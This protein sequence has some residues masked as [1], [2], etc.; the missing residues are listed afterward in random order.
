MLTRFSGGHHLPLKRTAHLLSA[1]R[2]LPPH[3][4]PGT[5]C[6]PESEGTRQGFSLSPGK[7]FRP[8]HPVCALEGFLSSSSSEGPPSPRLNPPNGRKEQLPAC[9]EKASSGPAAGRPRS[10]LPSG[11]TPAP[12]PLWAGSRR[13]THVV[14]SKQSDRRAHHG[15]I[16]EVSRGKLPLP[17]K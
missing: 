6:L 15:A 7:C 17:G 16:E 1:V 5:G 2:P 11:H 12:A 8:E 14:V 3:T 4:A 13:R 9:V 10:H